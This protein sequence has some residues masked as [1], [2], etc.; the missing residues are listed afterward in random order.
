MSVKL[1]KEGG[2]GYIYDLFPNVVFHCID[3]YMPSSV[4]PGVNIYYIGKGIT[5]YIKGSVSVQFK[6]FFLQF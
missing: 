3:I 6:A 1:L 2:V 4:D 5:I